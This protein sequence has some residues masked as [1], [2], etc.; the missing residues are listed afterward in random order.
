[1]YFHVKDVT[2]RDNTVVS[3]YNLAGIFSTQNVFQMMSLRKEVCHL[4]RDINI[5][6]HAKDHVI[7][8]KTN[9]AQKVTL[10]MLYKTLELSPC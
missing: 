10:V 1:M 3:D 6:L 7:L 5:S 4:V 9:S 8:N 2:V